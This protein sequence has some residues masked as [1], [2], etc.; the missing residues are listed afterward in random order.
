MMVSAILPELKKQGN[1]KYYEYKILITQ[2]LPE[3]HLAE[4]LKEYE[5]QLPTHLMLAYLPSEGLV[6]L[7]LSGRHADRQRLS[8]DLEQW[9]SRLKELIFHYIVHMGDQSLEQLIGQMLVERNQSL[10][11]G[12]SCTG[13]TI[14]GRITSVAGSSRYFKGS[15]VA[16]SNPVKMCMLEVSRS[17]LELHGAVSQQV[18]EEMARGT[19]KAFQCDY[20]ISVSGIAG[21]GGGTAHKSVGTTWIAVAGPEKIQTRRFHFGRDRELNIRKAANTAL[22]MLK[23]LISDEI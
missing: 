21:P 18:V 20:A 19:Q 10:A 1:S 8:R 6:R 5:G 3:A 22:V 12:E 4:K 11:T 14:A 23:R 7:R 13:G 9:L 16:Y 17:T 15:V 2:G